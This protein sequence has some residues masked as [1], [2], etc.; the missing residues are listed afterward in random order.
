M[1]R[2]LNINFPAPLEFENWNTIIEKIESEIRKLN[3]LPKGQQKS[4]ELQ[5]YSEAAKEFRY[6]KDAWRNHVS[7]SREKYDERQAKRIIEHVRDFM[8]HIA[9]R[10]KEIA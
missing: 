6:F 4:D 3:N 5:F 10:L 1:A 9:I 8:Q 2:E 7:H